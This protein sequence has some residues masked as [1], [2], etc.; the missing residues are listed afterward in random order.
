[1]ADRTTTED[2]LKLLFGETDVL[3][4]DLSEN[5]WGVQSLC[6]DW[7]VRACMTH[8][9]GV[10]A[11]LVGWKPQSADESPL[12]QK[13]GDFEAESADLDAAKFIE[14]VRRTHQTRT[15]ELAD[16]TD[17]EWAQPCVGPT[18]ATTYGRFMHI[19]VFD[20][21][22][23]LRDISIPLGRAT[24]DG[25]PAAEIA[26]DQ[27]H[28]SMG[29]IVG[30]K[31][32]LPDGMGITFELT[33]G[34]DRRIHVAVDGRAAV[35]D[36]LD[37]ADAVVVADATTFIMLACGRIDPQQQI[38]SG[39]IAWSGNSEWGEKAARNLRFTM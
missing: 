3:A 33:G 1:M 15:G 10:E 9:A 36:Q 28:Q 38:D 5:E 8:M 19:R 22:V 17:D 16:T 11:V 37:V 30:K 13:I 39:A 6:P 32:G 7:D 2:A 14:V 24:D 27:V 25:G 34:I 4:A 12:F 35:V 21:W 29:Y 26:L 31:I 23:H 18:G 20:Y